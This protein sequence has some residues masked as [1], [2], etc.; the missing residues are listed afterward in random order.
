MSAARLLSVSEALARVLATAPTP[1]EEEW[2]PLAQARG[3]TLRRN[4]DARRTQ[5]P[6]AVSAMDGYALR[7]ADIERAPASLRLVGSSAAGRAFEGRVAPGEAVRIFTGAPVPEG[8][9]TILMQEN[10]ATGRDGTVTALQ[11]EPLGRHVR[12]AGLDFAEGE[13]GL[14]A[15]RR[16]GAAELALAA[17]MN[18]AEVPVARQPRVA[19]LATGDELVLPGVTPGP[20]QIVASNGFALAAIVEAAGGVTVDLGIAGRQFRSPRCGHPGR[21]AKPGRRSG[22]ARRRLGRRS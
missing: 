15:G 4:L 22:H 19:I 17:A 21:P 9:D 20:S 3:R 8:A 12:R 11:A 5:P 16:L 6:V 2:V 1:L 14:A 7:A 10:A 18:Y 13:R